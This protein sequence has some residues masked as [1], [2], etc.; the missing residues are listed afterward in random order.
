MRLKEPLQKL[1]QIRPNLR[2]LIPEHYQKS[3]K[4]MHSVILIINGQY[5]V[6]YHG[7]EA[8]FTTIENNC[9]DKI[10]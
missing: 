2:N 7:T 9:F 10:T 1:Y 4:L 3:R 6:Q 8:D 5:C